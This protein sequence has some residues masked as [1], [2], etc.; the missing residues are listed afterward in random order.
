[1]ALLHITCLSP[2]AVVPQEG[3]T[4]AS[5]LPPTSASPRTRRQP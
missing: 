3:S 2:S 1:M 5:I 4:I